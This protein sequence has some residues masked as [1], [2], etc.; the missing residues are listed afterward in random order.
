MKLLNGAVDASPSFTI[1]KQ[2]LKRCSMRHTHCDTE[3]KKS[4][5]GITVITFKSQRK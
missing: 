5:A 1:L 3:V 4:V 2:T